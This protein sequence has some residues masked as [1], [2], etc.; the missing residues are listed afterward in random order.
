VRHVFGTVF[1]TILLNVTALSTLTYTEKLHS[2]GADS[3]EL[4]MLKLDLVMLYN[5]I[6][7][8]V[9]ADLAIFDMI[10][11]DLLRRRGHTLRIVKSHCCINARLYSFV[12]RNI[13]I[14][15]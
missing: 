2:L 1:G 3:L 9:D 13:N 14:L 5:I 6:Q 10:D 11:S 4:R 7:R 12:P 15:N 8:N